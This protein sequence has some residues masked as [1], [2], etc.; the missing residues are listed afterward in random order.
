MRSRVLKADVFDN[1]VFVARNVGLGH[2][3]EDFERLLKR[4]QPQRNLEVLPYHDFLQVESGYVAKLADFE[5]VL[6]EA[7]LF[8]LLVQRVAG[9]LES[10]V[11]EVLR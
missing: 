11:L 9:I 2:R 7:L 5:E 4:V 1:L 8:E 10:F 6:I 3:I